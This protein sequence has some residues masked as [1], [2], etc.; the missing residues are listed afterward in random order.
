MD[1][2]CDNDSIDI[3]GAP[4]SSLIRGPSW[5][6]GVGAEAKV[7]NKGGG[8]SGDQEFS[9]TTQE[10]ELN[11]Q[12]QSVD[13]ESAFV[14][15]TVEI[16][17]LY[18]TKKND[19]SS[20]YHVYQLKLKTQG[21][22]EWSIYRRY[23][24]FY[25]LH[26]ELKSV[27]PIIEKFQFPPKRMLNSKA[28]TIVQDRRKKLE[29]YMISLNSYLMLQ[30]PTDSTSSPSQLANETNDDNISFSSA[31]TNPTA[32]VQTNGSIAR[33]QK[34][35]TQDALRIYFLFICYQK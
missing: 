22:V 8:D 14:K 3:I 35:S 2:T 17:T 16:P 10:V 25:A 7:S 26:Q 18:L 31:I 23:S 21:G 13:L 5:S 33:T 19:A 6:F 12:T 9:D 11:L 28:S 20:S 15:I 32:R 1:A 4:S 29:D 27:D 24:Q 30:I 34:C